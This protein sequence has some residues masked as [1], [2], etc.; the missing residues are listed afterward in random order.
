MQLRACLLLLAAAL[1]ACD[2]HLRGS[3]LEA[4]RES[5]VYITADR[6]PGLAQQVKRQ[7]EFAGVPAVNTIG[8]AKYIIGLR[9]EFFN[10]S[11]LTVSADTGKVEEY[12]LT[13]TVNLSITGQDGKILL[14]PEA[15]TAQRYFTFDED[16][17]LGKFDEENKLR[18]ELTR[19]AADTVLRRL[20]A[21]TR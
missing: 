21:V 17:V 11:V 8:E 7:L 5:R 9:D 18:E 12:E 20:Q 6:A 14:Q 2:F 16:S 3:S 10:R 15:V 4:L 19:Y 13:Y 1:C